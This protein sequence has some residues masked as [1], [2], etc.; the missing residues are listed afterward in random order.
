MTQSS[1]VLNRS[2]CNFCLS[3]T[4]PSS[5]FVVRNTLMNAIAH[6]LI[7]IVT[8]PIPGSGYAALNVA[9]SNGAHTM[10]EAADHCMLTNVNVNPIP[11]V[12]SCSAGGFGSFF[13][14]YDSTVIG[15]YYY[16]I[17]SIY[18]PPS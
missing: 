8:D 18:H 1:F 4:I 13:S 15:N 3:P 6:E 12:N 9:G 14:Y 16:L 17:Q 11:H 5:V 2:V 7:E 10:Q